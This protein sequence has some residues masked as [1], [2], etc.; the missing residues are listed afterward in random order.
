M[1]WPS[2]EE[3]PTKEGLVNVKITV[4]K[5]GKV[6][7]AAY[8]PIK[9]TLTDSYHKEL[10]IKAARDAKFTTSATKPLRTGFITIRFELE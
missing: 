3:K 8:D 9:S 10:A 5:S 2:L 7:N 6:T 1:G 4:D